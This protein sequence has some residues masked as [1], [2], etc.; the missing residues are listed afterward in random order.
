MKQ[1]GYVRRLVLNKNFGFIESNGQDDIFFH[2]EDC[3]EGTSYN[4]LIVG[5]KVEFLMDETPK[6]P[7]A[8]DVETYNE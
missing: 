1:V 3:G 2:K 4:S 5:E 7:R 8:R 6:G